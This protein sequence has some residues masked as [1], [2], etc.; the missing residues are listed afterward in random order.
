MAPWRAIDGG[1]LIVAR[2]TPRGGRDSIDGV[3]IM[4]DGREVLKIRVRAAPENSEAN[5]AVVKLLAATL[6][7]RRSDVEVAAGATARVKQIVLRGDADALMAALMQCSTRNM[8]GKE[9]K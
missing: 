5:D 6:G 9:E 8:K 3:D 4:S 2:V 1:V 7:L